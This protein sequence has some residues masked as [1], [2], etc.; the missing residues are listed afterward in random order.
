MRRDDAVRILISLH[1]G[2]MWKQSVENNNKE[3]K[4]N[5]SLSF[6]FFIHFGIDVHIDIALERPSFGIRTKQGSSSN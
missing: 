6:D 4:S 5:E 3:V 1:D 2:H